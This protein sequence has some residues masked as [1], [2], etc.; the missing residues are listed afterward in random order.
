MKHTQWILG[1]LL[2]VGCTKT[3]HADEGNHPEVKQVTYIESKA[4][5]PNPERGFYRYSETRVDDYNL[6]E[7]EELKGYRDVQNIT[8]A[9]YSV[10]STLV[11]RYFI[12]EGYNNKPLPATFLENFKKDAATARKAGVKLIP[13]FTY[14]V[15]S[16]AGSCP[17]GF[18]CP[19]YGD[20]PKNMVLQHI[21]QLKP[22]LQENADVIACLQMGFIGTWG[23]NYYTD[24]FGDASSNGQSKLLNNN[25]ADRGEV[26]K[27]LLEALP[28]D[29]M[30][31]V[32]YPQVKQR[33]I[34]GV[35]APASSAALTTEEAAQ[36]NDK[37]RIGYHNDCFL[38]SAND[39]GTYEDY[40]NSS[41]PR[42]EATTAFRN[43]FSMDSRY[44]VVG[45]ET[46]SDDY[47]PQ[48]DCEPAGKAE[49]EFGEMHYSFLNAHYNAEVNNDWQTGGCMDNIKRKLGYRLVLKD[50]TFP[51]KVTPNDSVAVMINLQNVGYAAP[52][53]PRPVQLI[54][55][56][57][58]TGEKHV[59]EFNTEIRT[60]LTGS[61]Q[62]KQA[63]RLPA[64]IKAGS[65][66]MLLNLPDK[67]A[68]LKEMPAFSVQLANEQ[69][70][71]PATGYNQLNHTI[72]IQ[73]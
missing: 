26:L 52:Y 56:E 10:L 70:W 58:S 8:G 67:Y 28:P 25:W 13:R 38:A 16:N 9:G 3:N 34:Y 49:Q 22:L 53:N 1:L 2:T 19:P 12:L 51:D 73:N 24:Y 29:R 32:R 44:V 57:K 41:S 4:D 45:G 31:Q 30:V 65:Y 71:E 14:T 64:G 40:G 72:N 69:V 35:N 15:T 20:A 47:S 11:F 68:S 17:E 55:R 7:E 37:A 63:F 43:Y 54:L 18:I 60:W 61:I 36:E 39:Y 23:E 48:N 21:S 42:K 6:L 5:F 46:C 33:Y 66:E 59:F 62:L 50:G 27:A